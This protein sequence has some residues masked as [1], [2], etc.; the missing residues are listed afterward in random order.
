MR[1]LPW[2]SLGAVAYLGVVTTALTTWLQ[3]VGQRTVP[4]PQAS[5]LYTMEPVWASLFAW[6]IA[7]ESFGP[8]GWAGAALILAAAV[9]SQWPAGQARR[10]PLISSASP[11]A[12][13]LSRAEPP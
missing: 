3:A 2:V 8:T 9:G 1:H 13:N 12:A 11:E 6:L 5:L 10:E 4:G 7:G